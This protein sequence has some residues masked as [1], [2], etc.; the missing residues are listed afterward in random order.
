MDA[1]S[2]THG[3]N[4]QWAGHYGT[5]PCPVCQ[6]DGRSD[7][8]AL[9]IRDG[10]GKLLLHCKKTNCAFIDSLAAAG[11]RQGGYLQAEIQYH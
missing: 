10:Q 2:F 3:L 5:A 7:Q 9:T 1:R 6:P 4:G 11:L 8:N